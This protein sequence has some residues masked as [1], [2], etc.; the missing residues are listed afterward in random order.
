MKNQNRRQ[1]LKTSAALAAGTAVMQSCPM[2]ALSK[3]S[4]AAL[5]LT[6]LTQF[7]YRDVQ[8]LDGPLL[9]QFRQNVLSA[10]RRTGPGWKS[11]RG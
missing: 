1:F 11:A 7:E 9:V 5:V 10:R 2:K 6:K 8:L 4:G 3:P